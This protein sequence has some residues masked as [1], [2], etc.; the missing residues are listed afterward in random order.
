MHSGRTFGRA[1]QAESS[2]RRIS[3]KWIEIHGCQFCHQDVPTPPL[4]CIRSCLQPGGIRIPVRIIR[5]LRFRLKP[6]NK[7]NRQG[8]RRWFSDYLHHWISVVK[9]TTVYH[10]RTWKQFVNSYSEY[11]QLLFFFS[12][13]HHWTKLP[14]GNAFHRKAMTISITYCTNNT[15]N[16]IRICFLIQLK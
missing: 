12:L 15:Q 14:V 7:S 8:Q 11:L 16:Y 6:V 2:G 10:W 9:C 13:K 1:L 3:C 4:C 5:R